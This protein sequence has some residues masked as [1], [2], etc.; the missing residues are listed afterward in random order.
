[1]EAI[2]GKANKP[3]V[4]KSVT[5]NLALPKIDN[6]PSKLKNVSHR[7]FKKIDRRKLI[8][9]AGPICLIVVVLVGFDAF[10][11]LTNDSEPPQVAGSSVTEKA[12]FIPLIPFSKDSSKKAVTTSLC[13][14]DSRLI[15]FEDKYLNGELNVTQQELPPDQKIDP[16]KL[17][18]IAKASFGQTGAVGYDEIQTKNGNAVVIRYSEITAQRAVFV[19]QDRLVFIT[20]EKSYSQP[21]WKEYFDSLKV[22]PS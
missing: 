1:M 12:D 8:L 10:N 9:V 15:C 19:F 18:E 11:K 13:S 4:T 3:R 14:N 20:S 21:Q 17:I 2:K 22:A 7:Q 5:I 16:K 6:L